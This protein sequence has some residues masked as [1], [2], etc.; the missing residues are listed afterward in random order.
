MRISSLLLLT[1]MVAPSMSM[2]SSNCAGVLVAVPCISILASKDATPDFSIGS[3]QCPPLNT[4]SKFT[5]GISLLSNPYTFIPFANDPVQISGILNKGISPKAGSERSCF[6]FVFSNFASSPGS[7]FSFCTPAI[8]RFYPYG[9]SS[10]I[11]QRQFFFPFGYK[12]GY[13]KW[14]VFYVLIKY[15]YYIFFVTACT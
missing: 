10:G 3:A 8:N 14:F 12:A 2:A 15:S 4:T 6:V 7:T 11:I 1:V 13:Y 9:C 5:N